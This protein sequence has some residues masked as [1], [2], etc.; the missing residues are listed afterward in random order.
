MPHNTTAVSYW[1]HSIVDWLCRWRAKQRKSKVV[2]T[3]LWV[4]W[5]HSQTNKQTKYMEHRLI[6]GSTYVVMSSYGV[7]IVHGCGRSGSRGCLILGSHGRVGWVSAHHAPWRPHPRWKLPGSP[8][9]GIV[10]VI[11]TIIT[12]EQVFTL[13]LAFQA[14]DVSVAK[15]F[16]QLLDFFQLQQVDP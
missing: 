10:A 15:V 11:A 6:V 3:M 1:F 13:H 9:S 7:V 14:R 16:A 2:V 4:R 12:S 8:A 5:A